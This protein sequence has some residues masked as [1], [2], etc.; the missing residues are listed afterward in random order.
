MLTLFIN[1]IFHCALECLHF[2]NIQ[3]R[4]NFLGIF[5]LFGELPQSFQIYRFLLYYWCTSSILISIM[6]L[7]DYFYA[8]FTQQRSTSAT[9]HACATQPRDICG[10]SASNTSLIEPMQALPR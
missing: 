8:V 9:L 10:D 7:G 5:T 6:C 2:R 1:K 4:H 3:F